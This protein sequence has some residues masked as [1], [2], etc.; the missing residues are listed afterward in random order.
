MV[1][2]GRLGGSEGNEAA[3]ACATNGKRGHTPHATGS[4]HT[5]VT[6]LA[7][8]RRA[9]TTPAGS[10]ATLLKVII[11]GDPQRRA[12]V[13]LFQHMVRE[14]HGPEHAAM[15]LAVNQPRP[16]MDG[17][18]PDTNLAVIPHYIDDD[19]ALG[20][21]LG[22]SATQSLHL[23]AQGDAGTPAPV[24]APTMPSTEAQDGS[25]SL[26][27]HGSRPPACDKCGMRHGEPGMPATCIPLAR[28][29]SIG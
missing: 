12:S 25:A 23:F 13:N 16:A 17:P 15:W 14:K 5:L 28:T 19:P 3:D 10:A 8:T 11:A 6:L 7:H 27:D 26:Y 24:P 18:Q 9:C 22:P 20:T 21:S 1:S 2:E 29:I 4:I